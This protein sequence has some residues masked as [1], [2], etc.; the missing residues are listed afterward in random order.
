VEIFVADGHSKTGH[1]HLL[2]GFEQNAGVAGRA[3]I[4]RKVNLCFEGEVEGTAVFTVPFDPNQL[5]MTAY[6]NA[7]TTFARHL[8]LLEADPT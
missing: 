6:V 2:H 8:T 5:G 4:D 3:D 7:V 1:L